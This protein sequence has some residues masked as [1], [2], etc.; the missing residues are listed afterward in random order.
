MQQEDT[1]D[2][3]P[4]AESGIAAGQGLDHMVHETKSFAQRAGRKGLERWKAGSGC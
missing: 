4:A 3:I 2:K 1:K